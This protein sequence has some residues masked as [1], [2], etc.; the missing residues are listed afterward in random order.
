MS[1]RRMRIAP[2][3]PLVLRRTGRVLFGS[4]S[5]AE[6]CMKEQFWMAILTG[7]PQLKNVK[8]PAVVMAL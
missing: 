6:F 3:C 8:P 4:F 2:P 7:R 5:F 1:A